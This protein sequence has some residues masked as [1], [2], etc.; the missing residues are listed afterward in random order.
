MGSTANDSKKRDAKTPRKK[1]TLRLNMPDLGSFAMPFLEGDADHVDKADIQ[2]DDG[3]CH[4][5]SP[6][7]GFF[8]RGPFSRPSS[9]KSA[10]ARTKNSPGSPKTIFPYP[11]SHQDSPPKS[12][13]RLSFSGIFRSSSR[14]SNSTSPISIKL[15]SRARKA[16]GI[17]SPPSTPPTQ[18]AKQP[19]AFPLEAYRS[20]PERLEA[21]MRS[22]S[23]PPD[24]GQRFSLRCSKP[25]MTPSAPIANSRSRPVH[26]LAEGMLE[27]LDLEDEAF[28]E[29]ES[30]IYMRF[31]K[32]HKCYDIVPTSS[33]LV[34]FD[35]TL[36]VKK[37]FFALVAN[38]VRAAPLW[39]TKKQSFVG[40]LTIT[41]FINILHRYYKSPMVQIYELE[42]HQIETWRELYLQETFKPLVNISP[43]A[44]IFDAVYSLIK[45]KI[46][47]LP[48][49][50]PVSGN[51]LYILTH[52]R[53]L[54][55]LQLFVCE[56][57]KPAFMKQTLE[58]L[59]IGTYHN[60]AFIHPNTPII[61]ALNIFVDR[62]VSALPVVDESG[63]V[64]DIY[65]KF[66]VIN[67]AAEKTY[68]NLDIT[69]T[70]ALRHRSQYF[71]G[72]MKCNRLE[73]LETI[74]DRIVK[75]EV[76]RLVVVDE[77]ARIVGIVS[78]SDILQALVLTPAGIC[79]KNSQPQPEV[80][81]EAPPATLVEAEPEVEVAADTKLQEEAEAE[82]PLE[83]LVEAEPEVEVA[84]DTEPQEEATAEAPPEMLVEAEPEVEVPADTELQEE[85][86]AEAPPEM[87]VEA[88]PE[89]EEPPETLVETEVVVA[90]P[91]TEVEALVEAEVVVED[92]AEV[93]GKTETEVVV[94]VEIK[95]EVVEVKGETEAEIEA[96]V[97]VK[98]ETKAEEVEFKSEAGVVMVELVGVKAETESEVGM[99]E[100]E[101]EVVVVVE[102][103][104]E[105]EVEAEVEVMAETEA[106]VGLAEDEAEV[107]VV[108]IKAETEA[109][110]GNAEAVAESEA[111]VKV[112]TDAGPKDAEAE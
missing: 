72:V 38:G 102:I 77:N 79:R 3:S 92:E 16:S 95:T 32:S 67:L 84:A 105:T 85:A 53:I 29:S 97:E 50:D 73:T 99:T 1:R 42:E 88:E 93:E 74:V 9:P 87:L 39:E 28:E 37:A 57:P 94:E 30:D 68:N 5:A 14:D 109:E 86:E 34:V 106:A 63:K 111:V 35:T 70:Q 91:A 104:A 33:K 21:R 89:T 31:M 98:A 51:A 8:T 13:R 11:S 15:F 45:N 22:Y 49:I 60:I 25:P 110:V 55:F 26:G 17:S 43:D 90:E 81:A 20:E 10:P 107:V 23:S 65:S 112:E 71:E 6:T 18:A 19:P 78:L 52:K 62:R 100:D 41:D 12:P 46:H 7:K 75:A 61:K 66:D 27:K 69:V 44:S 59:T 108:E 40:M 54:K 4:S 56:M 64:V 47:R 101:A 58:E 36:Q 76:H 82:A 48:V 80:E 103:K 2:K 83:M 24:T 96:E